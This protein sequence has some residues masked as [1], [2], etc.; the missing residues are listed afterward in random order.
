MDFV[1]LHGEYSSER[2]LEI[3]QHRMYSGTVYY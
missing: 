2:I 3:G 1:K